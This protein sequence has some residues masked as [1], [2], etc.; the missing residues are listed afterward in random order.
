MPVIQIFRHILVGLSI[1]LLV[2]AFKNYLA[3]LLNGTDWCQHL[4]PTVFGWNYLDPIP[5][6]EYLFIA[7]EW[8]QSM[9]QELADL[10]FFDQRNLFGVLIAAPVIE[11]IIYRGPLFLTK[12]YSKRPAWWLTGLILV[13]VFAL[14]H[15]RSGIALMPLLALGSFNLWLVARTQRMWPAVFLHFLHNFIILSFSLY[16]SIWFGD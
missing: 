8:L 13:I 10:V 9:S 4:C 1:V 7:Q 12:S 3:F 14:S 2:C 16:P 5:V 15:G 11:E 6:L